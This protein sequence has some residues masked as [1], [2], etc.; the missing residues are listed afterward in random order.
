MGETA[1]LARSGEHF[2]RHGSEFVLVLF[3]LLLGAIEFVLRL[4]EDLLVVVVRGELNQLFQ[5]R[6]RLRIL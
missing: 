1:A 2:L 5:T 6:L 4:D 3:A